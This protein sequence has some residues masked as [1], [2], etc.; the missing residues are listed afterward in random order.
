[1]KI[2]ISGFRGELPIVDARLLPEANAQVA[3][4]VYLRHGTLKPE[5]TPGA[6]QGIPSVI[7]PSSIYRYPHGNNGAGYWLAWG[8]GKQVNVVK[9]LLADDAWS[10]VYWTGDG[11]PKMGGIADVTKG[12]GPYPSSSFRLGIPAPSDAPVA[13]TPS[14]RVAAADQPITAVQASYV[15]TLVSRF[16]EEGAPS[17]A[18]SPVI[19]WDMVDGA[20]AGGGVELSLPSI[21]SG[22]YQIITKRIYRA[23]SAGVFQFVADVPA[24]QGVFTDSVLSESL[25]ISLPSLEWDMPDDRLIGLTEMPGGFLA[26]FFGNTLCFSEAWYPHAWPVSNQLAFSD[27]IVGIAAVAN[28]LV[29]ATKGRPHLITGSTPAAMADMLIDADQ[30]CVSRRSLVDM[31][32]YAI[33]ASPDG[34]IAI[35]GNEAQLLTQAMISKDQWQSLLPET[36]HAYRYDGRYLAFYQ[37]G[38]FSFTPDDGFEFYDVVAASGYYDRDSDTLYLIQG[39]GITGWRQGSPMTLRWRS[40]I[41]ETPP[42]GSGFTCAKVIARGYPVTFRLI[43]DG[44]TM[45]DVAVPGRGLFRL[46]AGYAGCHDWE[47][48]VEGTHEIQSIQIASSPS[49]L[50]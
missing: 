24:A 30:P 23:E 50:I 39:N 26:G 35:G 38:C 11:P 7:S 15:V 49:E 31:G 8:N 21:P 29:V 6:V 18:S 3:R 37:G 28:G 2:A 34:L 43:A 36:I 19:R 42:G 4:N 27:D 17:L 25:G 13:S 32:D 48:E 10:R 5:R 1:M 22:A 47:I 44:V 33:Y 16:G 46:P 14:D 20:P 45:L 9:S 12:T 40:K 41:H